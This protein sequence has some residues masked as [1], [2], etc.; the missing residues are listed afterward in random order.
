[1]AHLCAILDLSSRHFAGYCVAMPILIHDAALYRI[2]LLGELDSSWSE[3]LSG[4]FI[5]RRYRRDGHVIT[6]LSGVL[7][8]QAA[9]A[10]VLN[11]AICL[12]MPILSVTWLGKGAPSPRATF[13]L[14]CC[15]RRPA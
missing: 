9:L 1:M 15:A 6:T 2:E 8:D 13:D 3:E 12:G 5:D 11:L 14:A 7:A 10:V 4:M